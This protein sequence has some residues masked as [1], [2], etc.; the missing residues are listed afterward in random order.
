MKLKILRNSISKSKLHAYLI[1]P[2]QEN[3]G[4]YYL[5]QWQPTYGSNT[6][7]GPQI[8]KKLLMTMKITAVLLLI[9]LTRVSAGTYAQSITYTGKN[10]SLEKVFEAIEKQTDY[11]VFYDYRQIAN[12]RPITVDV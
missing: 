2:A 4:W 11:V 7:D 5:P 3:L 6:G 12:A 10:V 9:F 8:I 1:R